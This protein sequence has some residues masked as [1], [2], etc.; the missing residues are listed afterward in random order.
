MRLTGE[1]KGIVIS[2]SAAAA[3]TVA[4]LS[5]AIILRRRQEKRSTQEAALREKYL[6][7]FQA[8]SRKFF[9]ICRDVA[10]VA[11]RVRKNIMD[12]GLQDQ[13]TD[14][15]LKQ[16]MTV[17]CGVVE[18]LAKA[19]EEVATTHKCTVEDI[20]LAQVTLQRSDNQVQVLAD[21]FQSMLN[22]AL[23]GEEP[24]MPGICIQTE[25]ETQ[26]K[27]LEL[28]CEMHQLARTKVYEH[29]SKQ[30]SMTMQELIPVIT[31]CHNDAVSE[32][33]GKNVEMLGS[34]LS[35]P[36]SWGP[37]QAEEVYYSAL[38]LCSKIPAFALKR[39][40]EDANFRHKMKEMLQIDSAR[41]SMPGQGGSGTPKKGKK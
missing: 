12:K 13:V 35:P 18:K 26:R 8:V 9:H 41:N 10:E 30:K 22:D 33:L 14:V 2:V 19:Q 23:A 20:R 11:K 37:A 28:Y 15:A 5:T 25:G 27:V 17:Q 40:K 16:Q 39:E 21:S 6:P 24:I 38:T 3:I 32:V 31:D 1:N 29:I 7:A 4:S 34:L 36:N